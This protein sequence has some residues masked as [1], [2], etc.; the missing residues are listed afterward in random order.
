MRRLAYAIA[1]ALIFTPQT[2]AAEVTVIGAWTLNRDRTEMPPPQD[3]TRHPPAG[4]GGGR[5]GGGRGGGLPSGIPGLGGGGVPNEDEMHKAES[6]RRRLVE[7]PDR[8][9]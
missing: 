6:I 3:E 5:G 4:R 7:I 8:L 9:I 2:F 1:V